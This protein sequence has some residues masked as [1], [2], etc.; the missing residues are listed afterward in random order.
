MVIGTGRGSSDVLLRH[1]G[2][3]RILAE[4]PPRQPLRVLEAD[5]AMAEARWSCAKSSFFGVS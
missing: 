5:A 3:G 2:R 1:R 4:E